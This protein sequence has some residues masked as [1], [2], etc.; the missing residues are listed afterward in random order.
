M[1]LQKRIITLNAQCLCT[2]F[3]DLFS[4]FFFFQPRRIKGLFG[5]VHPL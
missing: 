5:S 4:L 3:A 1:D 2:Q